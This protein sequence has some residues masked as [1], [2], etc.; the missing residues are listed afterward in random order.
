MEELLRIL[1]EQTQAPLA[2]PTMLSLLSFSNQ[3]EASFQYLNH[4]TVCGIRSA[5]VMIPF[6]SRVIVICFFTCPLLSMMMTG[7]A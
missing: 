4:C 7:C 3:A 1:K 2:E 5:P 6:S